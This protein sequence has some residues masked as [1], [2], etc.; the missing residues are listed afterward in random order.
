MAEVLLADTPVVSR[1]AE[2]EIN[3]KGLLNEIDAYLARVS[4][5]EFFSSGEV[6]DML[7]DVRGLVATIP[8]TET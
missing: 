3:N 2:R 5:R 7:L 8:T 1:D 4:V 6:T